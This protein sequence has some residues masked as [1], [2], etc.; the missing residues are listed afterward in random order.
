VLSVLAWLREGVREEG[1]GGSGRRRSECF[2]F[3]FSSFT[4]ADGK[5]LTPINLGRR[6]MPPRRRAKDAASAPAAAPEPRAKSPPASPNRR[7]AK[8][9]VAPALSPK[10]ASSAKK[11]AAPA[12][13]DPDLRRRQQRNH[14]R[15][16]S[17]LAAL[18]ALA[19]TTVALWQQNKALRAALSP[20][21]QLARETELFG[22][23]VSAWEAVRDGVSE[24]LRTGPARGSV[25]AS[26][27]AAAAAAGFGPHHPVVLVPG[28]VTSSL[29]LWSGPKCAQKY[30]R[31]RFWGGLSM[32]TRLLGDKRCWLET[33]ALD[34]RTGLDP[35]TSRDDDEE[36]DE[37]EEKGVNEDG[38]G[39][40]GGDAEEKKK[41]KWNK[42]RRTTRLRAVEGLA[43]VDYFMPGKLLLSFLDFFR[44]GGV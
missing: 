6:K 37:G 16:L 33:M 28:F 12:V 38:D 29:E 21:A 26:P 36:E 34:Q 10:K 35:V 27:G 4:L 1:G 31:S 9:D 18:A 41:P 40:G 19:A 3:F 23:G 43:G 17:A 14:R 8:K 13:D 2:S 11:P 39:D 25:A 44:G 7:A 24:A 42:R 5:T 22:G 30:F 15:L 32:T 20:L